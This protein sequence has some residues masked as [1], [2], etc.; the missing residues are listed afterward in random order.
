[1]NAYSEPVMIGVIWFQN[2]TEAFPI[3]PFAVLIYVVIFA[4]LSEKI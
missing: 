1:M 4:F 3:Y 2:K